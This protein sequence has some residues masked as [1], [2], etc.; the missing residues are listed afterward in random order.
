MCLIIYKPKGVEISDKKLSGWCK[1]GERSNGDGTGFVVKCGKEVYWKK[2]TKDGLWKEAVAWNIKEWD[3]VIH[4]RSKTSQLA[5]PELS[6][7][8]LISKKRDKFLTEG[9]LETGETLFLHNG[10]FFSTYTNREE[11]DTSIIAG[12]LKDN[13]EVFKRGK[14]IFIKL[15]AT[16]SH[17]RIVFIDRKSVKLAGDWEKSDRCYFS[18]NGYR[19]FQYWGMSYNYNTDMLYQNQNQISKH[20]TTIYDDEYEDGYEYQDKHGKR[21]RVNFK[22]GETTEKKKKKRRL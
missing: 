19:G 10:I 20:G 8:F 14:K 17:S 11:S 7:P 5:T 12:N 18:N 4:F 1:N 16:L 9:E 13:L 6:H 22:T 3:L 15:L 2:G 21:Y